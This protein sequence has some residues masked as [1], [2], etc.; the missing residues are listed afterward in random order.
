MFSSNRL[1]LPKMARE[2]VKEDEA[3]KCKKKERKRN[4]EENFL[5]QL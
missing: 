3:R 5:G 4:E 1:R 2:N